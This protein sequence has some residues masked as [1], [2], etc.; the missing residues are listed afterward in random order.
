[1][2]IPGVPDGKGG[3]LVRLA[4]WYSRRIW[5]MVLDPLRVYALAPRVMMAFGKLL[6]SIEKPRKLPIG[7]KSLAMARTAMQVGC[8]F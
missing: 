5:G 6:R 7:L 8:P 3:L 2:R 1:M 4:Y